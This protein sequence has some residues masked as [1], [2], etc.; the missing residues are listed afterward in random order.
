[1]LCPSFLGLSKGQHTVTGQEGECRRLIS[2]DSPLG[3]L[4]D[5][6]ER[7]GGNNGRD[8]EVWR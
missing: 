6:G 4:W 8:G 1:M 7:S 5:G 2:S 3:G